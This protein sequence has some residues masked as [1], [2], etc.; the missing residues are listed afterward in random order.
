MSE[1][2]RDKEKDR[3]REDEEEDMCVE[4]VELLYQHQPPTQAPLTPPND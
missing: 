2:D 1:T 4:W 3:D